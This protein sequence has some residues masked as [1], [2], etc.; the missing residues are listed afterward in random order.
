MND[1]LKAIYEILLD[2]NSTC[3]SCELRLRLLEELERMGVEE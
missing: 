2:E 1:E 3:T